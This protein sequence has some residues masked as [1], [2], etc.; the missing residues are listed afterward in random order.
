MKFPD[1]SL[2]PKFQISLTQ[3]KIPWLF[4]DLELFSFFTDF[5]LTVGTLQSAASCAEFQAP[6]KTSQLLVKE[7]NQVNSDSEIVAYTFFLFSANNW[8]SSEN[9]NENWL[10]ITLL[11]LA[12]LSTVQTYL[13]KILSFNIQ[14]FLTSI[15]TYNFSKL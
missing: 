14:Y 15:K 9:P 6:S 10:F 4:P 13:S 7:S 8:A 1:F 5:S 2:F 3:I 12:I 11:L